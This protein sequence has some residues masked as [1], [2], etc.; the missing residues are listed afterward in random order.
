[1]HWIGLL[2]YGTFGPPG[3]TSYESSS[4][5]RWLPGGS[6]WEVRRSRSPFHHRP[7]DRLRTPRC[8]PPPEHR[9]PQQ[10][11]PANLLLT[12]K[13][14]QVRHIA[15]YIGGILWVFT[16]LLYFLQLRWLTKKRSAM[17]CDSSRSV[18]CLHLHVAG[19]NSSTLSH[20]PKR[21]TKWKKMK[22]WL[23]FMSVMTS[24]INETVAS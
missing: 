12:R 5:E 7:A 6:R 10:I 1:M 22:K 11:L 17:S 13:I 14:F 20:D 19:I 16:S 23:I 9:H 21:E 15:K 4:P 8:P 18:H 2:C 3:S 24:E